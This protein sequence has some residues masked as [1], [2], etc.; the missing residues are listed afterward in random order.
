M[1]TAKT[2]K[3][4]PAEERPYE[5]CLRFGPEVLSDSELLAIILRSGTTGISSLDLA[6]KILHEG[7]GESGLLGIHHKSLQE[8]MDIRGIGQV[9][10]I[11]IKCIGELSKRIAVCAAKRELNFRCPETIAEYYMEQLRHQEQEQVICMMLDTKNHLLGDK[12]V[13]TGTVN[14]SLISTRD[15]MLAALS[16][17][18]VHIILIHNHPS[19]DA[20][21]SEDDILLTQKVQQACSIIDIPLLDHIIIGD[22]TYFS[23]REEG[24]L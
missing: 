20:S 10:A 23:F 12:V 8:L 6:R 18:A 7:D 11:Q 1:N 19:G 15:L 14:A 2:M 13:T 21:P 9:K 24:I 3:D 16:Y 22:Q 17:R 5:K 4:L